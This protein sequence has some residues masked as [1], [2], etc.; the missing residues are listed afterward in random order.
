M[1]VRKRRIKRLKPT[2]LALM[3]FVIAFGF[4]LVS[5]IYIRSYNISLVKKTAIINQEI[6]TKRSQNEALALEIQQLSAYDRVMAIA[7]ADNLALNQDNIVSV[8]D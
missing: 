1:A 4:Y 2:A 7:T 5:S 3:I 8:G 6:E